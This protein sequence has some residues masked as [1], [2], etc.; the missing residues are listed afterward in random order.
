[1]YL[2]R[3]I[4]RNRWHFIL[5]ESYL[6]NGCYRSRDLLE[7]GPDPRRYVKY[8]GGSNFFLDDWVVDSLRKKGVELDPFEL[9]RLFFPYLDPLVR[10]RMEMFI[11]RQT[12]RRWKPISAAMRRKI[13]ESTHE[14]DRRRVHFLRF[15]QIDQR[16]LDRPA[17]IYRVLLDKS[18]DEI[19]QYFLS[20]EHV[21]RPHEYKSYMYAIFDLQRFFTES[22]ASTMPEALSEEKLDQHFIEQ[23]CRLDGDNK[24]WEGLRRDARLSGYLVRY[25]IMYFDYVFPSGRGMEEYIRNF[26]D[27][28][29]RY[30][31]RRSGVR[32]SMAEA[33]T[34]FGISRPELGALTR[35]QLKRLFRR[36]AREMHPDKGGSHEKFIELVNAYQEILRTKAG[37]F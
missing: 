29:R 6:E 13:L 34:I 30:V 33:A 35:I 17:A 26:M 31:P 9:E 20:E 36:K 4:I 27:A 24:F 7:L 28:R 11:D 25:V 2:A 23:I 18:R 5:R 15:G 32:V 10:R 21:L 19:E 12:Y 16:R 8:A 22:F 37:K 3:T 1:M 14:F